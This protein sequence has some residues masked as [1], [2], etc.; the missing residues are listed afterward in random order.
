MTTRTTRG[1]DLD[2]DE[3]D[4]WDLDDD[5]DDTWPRPRRRR[6]RRVAQTKTTTRTTRGPDLDDEDEDDAVGQT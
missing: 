6:G 5:E 1:P 2:D 3:D 4:T